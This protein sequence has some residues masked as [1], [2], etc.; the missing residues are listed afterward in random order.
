MS[1]TRRDKELWEAAQALSTKHA[2]LFA[3]GHDGAAH[4]DCYLAREYRDASAAYWENRNL[5]SR[6]A[7]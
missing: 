7:K 5:S 2:E 1:L 4:C 3:E 6:G